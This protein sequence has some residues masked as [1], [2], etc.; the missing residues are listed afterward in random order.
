MNSVRR[1]ELNAV[2]NSTFLTR[3]YFP[4]KKWQGYIALVLLI[5]NLKNS[6]SGLGWQ[7]VV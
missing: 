4:S 5:K 1:T 3:K 2:Y 7:C 6:F